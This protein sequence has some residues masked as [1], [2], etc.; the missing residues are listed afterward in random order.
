MILTS[1]SGL[2]SAESHFK[3]PKIC[4]VFLTE[5]AAADE[6][7]S[8]VSGFHRRVIFNHRNPCFLFHSGGVNPRPENP[9]KF[10]SHNGCSSISPDISRTGPTHTH[11]TR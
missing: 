9:I 6:G 7:G 2:N 8:E 11:T 5:A 4:V 1:F 10:I 3:K